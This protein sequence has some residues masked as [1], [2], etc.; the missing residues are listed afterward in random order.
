MYIATIKYENEQ[1]TYF[2]T[3]PLEL[4]NSELTFKIWKYRGLEFEKAR[5]KPR[6]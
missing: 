1:E 4:L 3:Q 2:K 6:L 5:P